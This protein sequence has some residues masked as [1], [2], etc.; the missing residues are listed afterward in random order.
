MHNGETFI[1]HVFVYVRDKLLF[2][3]D[4]T[5]EINI[6]KY[7]RKIEKFENTQRPYMMAQTVGLVPNPFRQILRD[8]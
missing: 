6:N 5:W 8:F 7:N 1:M 4:E 3:S 2:F